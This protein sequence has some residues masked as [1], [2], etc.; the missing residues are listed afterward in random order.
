MMDIIINS[1][2]NSVKFHEFKIFFILEYFDNLSVYQ[3]NN[4]VDNYM[5]IL[6]S[7]DY[8]SNPMLSQYNTVK[9]SLLIYR[10]SWRI[11]QK[12]IYSLITKCQLLNNYITRGISSYLERQNHIAQLYKFMRE[13]IFSLKERQDSL[14]IMYEMKMEQ[15]LKHPVIVELLNLVYQGQYSFEANI[16]TL[17]N[18]FSMYLT[19]SVND[20]KSLN[21]ALL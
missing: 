11:N 7:K 1:I 12:K 21:D 3:L 16:S 8:K 4:I 20:G 5:E 6:H 10:I 13:P 2:K 9:Y 17:S 18:T 15:L 19:S 14:D